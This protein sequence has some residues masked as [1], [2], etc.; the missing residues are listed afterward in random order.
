MKSKLVLQRMFAGYVING[1]KNFLNL[2]FLIKK[3]KIFFIKTKVL[4][5]IY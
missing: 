5:K 3:K 2:D 1:M 4:K